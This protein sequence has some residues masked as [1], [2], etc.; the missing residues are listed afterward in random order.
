MV[1]ASLL[2]LA[3]GLGLGSC[4]SS[5]PP[6]PATAAHFDAIQRQEAIQDEVRVAVLEPT[7][8]CPSVCTGTAR[9]CEAAERI[10]SIA[11]SVTDADAQSRCDLA[12]D[13]CTQYRTAATRCE[14]P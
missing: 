13:R 8:E 3:L 9:G 5:E 4:A 11:A 14:C 10:C 12:T 1:R 7:T 2:T 6:P